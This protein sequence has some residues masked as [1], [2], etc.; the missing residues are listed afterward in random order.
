M[1]KDLELEAERLALKVIIWPFLVFAPICYF[2]FHTLDIS[3]RNMAFYIGATFISVSLVFYLFAYLKKNI[4]ELHPTNASKKRWL[5]YFEAFSMSIIY[6]GMITILTAVIAYLVVQAYPGA[7]VLR[8][9]AAFSGGFVASLAAYTAILSA[10]ESEI[11]S[12]TRNLSIFMFGGL[13]LSAIAVSDPNWYLISFSQLGISS[14]FA[15]KIFNFTLIFTGL[16]TLVL[17]KYFLELLDNKVP[18]KELYLKHKRFLRIIFWNM[19][20]GIMIVGLVPWAPG[21]Q[22]IVHT[23]GAMLAGVFFFFMTAGSKK[24]IPGLYSYF[25]LLSYFISIVVAGFYLVFALG[26]NSLATVEVVTFIAV[27][28]WI[29]LTIKSLDFLRLKSA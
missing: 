27:F 11:M 20:I 6:T 1:A 8:L 3:V 4:N 22:G 28:V 14:G 9:A 26:Y 17:S 18:D 21:I 7:H 10:Y 24:L 25:Y 29:F 23:I 19:G 15:S 13:L 2:I 12:I 16:G 5:P